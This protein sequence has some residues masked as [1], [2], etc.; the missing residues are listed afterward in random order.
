MNKTVIN[1]MSVLGCLYAQDKP[2]D[3]V[4]AIGQLLMGNY[5]VEVT[6]AFATTHSVTEANKMLIELK[7]SFRKTFQD[8]IDSELHKDKE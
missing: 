5:D 6:A 1:G 4:N 8:A 2:K 7:A 3:Q